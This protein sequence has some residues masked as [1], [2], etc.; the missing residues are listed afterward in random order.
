MT[1]RVE[2]C[3]CSW[4]APKQLYYFELINTKLFYNGSTTPCILWLLDLGS[5]IL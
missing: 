4:F 3:E 1:L 2:L 5:A